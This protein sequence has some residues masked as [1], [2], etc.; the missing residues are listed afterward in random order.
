MPSNANPE[1]M[2]KPALSEKLIHATRN[3]TKGACSKCDHSFAILATL[4]P[5]AVERLPHA[6]RFFDFLRARC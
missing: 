5:A 2:G 6:K 4:N 1:T 3:T